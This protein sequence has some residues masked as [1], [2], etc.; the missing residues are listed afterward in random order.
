MRLHEEYFKRHNIQGIPLENHCTQGAV[1]LRTI[2]PDI[3]QNR[4]ILVTIKWIEHPQHPGSYVI[5]FCVPVHDGESKGRLFTRLPTAEKEWDEYEDFLLEWT[6]KLNGV[7]PVL[8][9]KQIIL[10][11]WE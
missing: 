4:W 8:G 3:W 11:A 7:E 5:E 1:I 10:A 2:D 6:E 9:H